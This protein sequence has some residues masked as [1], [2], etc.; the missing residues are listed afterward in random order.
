MSTLRIPVHIRV[1]GSATDS[2]NVWHFRGGTSA[3]NKQTLDAALARL[4]DFYAGCKALYPNGVSITTPDYATTVAEDPE[5]VT[6]DQDKAWAVQGTG[7]DFQA[8]EVL[9]LVATWT[10]SNASRSGR[11]RTFVG[12][13]A[14]NVLDSDGSPVD[15]KVTILRNAVGAMVQG[16]FLDGAPSNLVVYS[17]VQNLARD[18]ARGSVKDRFAI[19]RSRRD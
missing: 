12:P 7:G 10:T 17:Q 15:A 2:I 1:P 4:N 5:Y 3:S 9:Q 14:G 6:V 16:N 11:G 8:P 13:L 18:V 19:L